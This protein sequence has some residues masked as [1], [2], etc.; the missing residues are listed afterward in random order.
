MR[1]CRAEMIRWMLWRG[2][3][4]GPRV[5]EEGKAPNHPRTLSLPNINLRAQADC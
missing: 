1:I 5:N 3:A 2:S 4:L